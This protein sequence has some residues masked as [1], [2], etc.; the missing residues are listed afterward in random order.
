MQEDPRETYRK[1]VERLLGTRSGLA[2]QVLHLAAGDGIARGALLKRLK[3]RT[4]E[5][6]A[7]LGEL[8]QQHAI[9]LVAE[10]TTGRPRI[11][12]RTISS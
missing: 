10:R 6:D 8:L 4:E 1:A 7:L 2:E 3:I 11:L 9:E 12:I 5:L